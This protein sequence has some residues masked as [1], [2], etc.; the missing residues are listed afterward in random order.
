M[1]FPLVVCVF[2]SIAV[3]TISS[4]GQ[5][6]N[7]NINGL[8]SDPSNAAVA[9][10]EIVA[11]NDVT[12][13]QF[14]TKTNGEGIYVLPNLPPGPYRVQV[15]K[16]GF[17]T[18]I[19][20]EIVL[21]VQDSLSINF[22]LLVG[23]FHEIVTVQGG[24]PLVDTENATVSTVVDRQFVENLPLNGRSFQ[25]L[26]E[27]TPG[28]VLTPANS[29]DQ[30]QFS[31]NGQR[32]NSNYFTVDGVSANTGISGLGTGGLGQMGG[33]SLPGLS[34][35]GSTN[36]L[37]AVDAMQEFRMQTSTFAPEFGRTP[38]AQIS[39]LTRS[40][41]NQFHGTL[42]EY[43]RNDAL[44]AND[45]FANLN[46]LPRPAERINDF[47]GVFGGPIVRSKTFF[48]FSYEGQRLRL[49]QTGVT[50]VPSLSARQSAPVDIQPYLNAFPIPNGT[51]LGSGQAQFNSGYSDRASLDA[52]SLRIDHS[53]SDRLTLFARYS[54]SPS[55]LSQ[56]GGT[57]SLNN[58]NISKTQ[59]QT[60]TVGSNW[61]LKP[62]LNVEGRLNYSRNRAN[63]KGV[64]DGFGG[65]IVPPDS[66]LFPP[67]Y[68][69][70]NAGYDFFVID[71]QQMDWFSGR[72]A[73][74]EQRQINAIGNVTLLKGTHTLRFGID[75]LRLT[76][77]FVPSNYFANPLFLDIPSVISGSSLISFVQANR[78]GNFAFDDLS[79]FAQDNWRPLRRLTV[80][81]GARWE[82]E[83]APSTTSGP[84]FLAVTGF[85]SP[86][87]LAIAPPGTA[88]WRTRYK[89]LAPRIGLAYEL[90]DSKDHE[91]VLR[92]GFG[93]F[94][95]L[96]TQQVG[97]AIGGTSYP[98][99]AQKLL[100][101]A[102]FPLNATDA[103]PPSISPNPPL[104]R[105][106]AFDPG[107]RLPYTLQYSLTFEQSLGGEQALSL[108]YVGAA[109]RRLLQ[110][111]VLENPNSDFV[112]AAV[113]LNS[114][115]S[116]YNALQ[117]QFH[118]RL[119]A[120]LQLLASYTWAHS[121]D[122]S[123]SDAGIAG[124]QFSFGINP[125]TNRGSSDFDIRS[126][127]AAG[128][129][130]DF[131]TF[132]R[133]KLTRAVFSGW[134]TDN[135]IQ[136]RTAPPID[137]VTPYTL[138]FGVPASV[139]PDVVPGQPFYL[140]GPQCAEL[141]PPLCPGNK[142]L[143]P[144]AF[145]NPPIDPTTQQPIRQ[146]D[147]GRNALRAFGS[148]QWDFAIRRQFSLGE[149]IRLQFRAEFF[150]VLNHPNFGPPTNVLGRPYFG[151]STQL[152]GRSLGGG[153]G[154]GSFT[155][156]YQI[157]GPRSIQLGLKLQF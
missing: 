24:A 28:V 154:D 27:L 133:N 149:P 137:V 58:V 151:E 59:A 75:Y 152:L 68:S 66:V 105:I 87:T 148:T 113:V 125:N 86:S 118:R 102:P 51:D 153:G 79:L 107:L 21:N 144:A 39:I 88:L 44:D 157:G 62:T 140:T 29:N 23:A 34:V 145:T 132:R 33:A 89:N 84:N 42:F 4:F 121:I 119:S 146:G 73:D 106:V 126:S 20:P 112:Q 41:T 150:N 18:L 30:G 156:L 38:G 100:F 98:F 123:S 134:A 52:A 147:L 143:N 10:A 7:G 122:D 40:G 104:G 135:L 116:S 110:Q 78:G 91:S 96:A 129:T 76:P 115:T 141:S 82:L 95:D 99:G 56:R 15:S 3:M 97:A 50:T 55:E 69:S 2:V 64:L 9:D 25:T 80:T 47:G 127:F 71:G 35:L 90:N 131:P 142:G 93:V 120:G 83:P 45:W 138:L 103:E 155:Q 54:Y 32:A 16:I 77:K 13:V 26:I 67:S 117:V 94:Y 48:F 6:P 130:Y 63:S 14:T 101:G 49:P 85:G 19:K 53:F 61:N 31:V 60:L 1:C 108:S 92:T 12:G 22:T 139:R 128:L 70:A 81:Y 57:L 74:N 72:V 36:T 8:I 111:G 17:K 136:G 37:V 124:N 65:A 5:S 109:G 46:R 114:A 43:F 11:V